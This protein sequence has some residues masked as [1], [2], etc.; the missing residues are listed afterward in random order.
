[1]TLLAWPLQRNVIRRGVKNNAFGMVRNGGARSHQGWDLMAT[2]LTEC[3]AIADGIIT[4]VAHSPTYGHCIELKFEH[5]AYVRPLYAFY[6]HLSFQHVR[7][8]EVVRRGQIIGRTGNSGN[9]SSMK[10][11]DQH[12]HFEIRTEPHLIATGLQGRLDPSLLYGRS[13][14]A[15][16][17]LDGHGEAVS[18]AGTEGLKVQG[19]NV[20]NDNK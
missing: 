14:L 8:R 5:R 11:E 4:N 15:H 10:G 1:M 19:V 20:R 16:T 18:T 13:P 2:P 12:L 6:A 17:F 9:A 3:Y 7:K